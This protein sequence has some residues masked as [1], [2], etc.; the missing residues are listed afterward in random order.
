[1]GV[2]AL[3]LVL[4][5]VEGGLMLAGLAA[6][7]W[8]VALP[9]G[10][11]LVLLVDALRGEP[12]AQPA[13]AAPPPAPEVSPVG[14]LAFRL[15]ES[16]ERLRQQERQRFIAGTVSFEEWSA[17]EGVF[18][19][20]R[21]ELDE[22][23]VRSP[24]QV[25]GDSARPARRWSVSE[26]LL[27][28]LRK[29][30]GQHASTFAEEWSAAQA[31]VQRLGQDYHAGIITWGQLDLGI[32]QGRDDVLA[33]LRQRANLTGVLARMPTSSAPVP[34]TRSPHPAPV[35]PPEARPVPDA[36]VHWDYSPKEWA[37]F[38]RMD[39]RMGWRI[40]KW[41]LIALPWCVFESF[42]GFFWGGPLV[43]ALVFALT[44][45]FAF[46]LFSL[47]YFF[48]GE[49]RARHLA[50]CKRDQ[51]RRVTLSRDGIWLAGVHFP[52]GRLENVTMTDSPPVLHFRRSLSGG[53]GG[54][55]RA[56]PL[57]V[58]HGHE[59]EAARL[60]QRYHRE[61][62]EPRKQALERLNAPPPE[63]R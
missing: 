21:A 54:E 23:E 15:E 40:A 26:P 38:D 16:I 19:A 63:P 45:L 57:L 43:I 3:L 55:R 6:A 53:T 58:P 11:L 37:R 44:L 28:L 47:T 13:L 42:A 46:G 62:I 5:V 4:G 48:A 50:R 32:D 56:L 7:W 30:R 60:M 22:T 27:L 34:L 39:W 17:R 14:A 20:A 36:W 18:L 35:A 24:T 29:G 25:S 9:G 49:D 59:E 2:V 12:A 52:L 51:P 1:L 33:A 41:L 61:V 10:V 31:K 8:V